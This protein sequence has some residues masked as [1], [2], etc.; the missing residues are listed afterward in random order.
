MRVAF[1]LTQSLE[2]PS[3]LGRYF[4]LAKELA[5]REY[6][7]HIIAPHHCFSSLKKHSLC[8][9]GVYIHYVSQMHVKKIGNEK[10]YFRPVPLLWIAFVSTV[11]LT[12][13]LFKIKPDIVQLGKPQPMNGLAAWIY[14]RFKRKPMYVDC[15]DYEAA[16]NR[17][18]GKWQRKAIVWFEDNLPLHADAVTVNTHFTLKRLISVGCAPNRIIYV[19]NGVD[20]ARFSVADEKEVDAL[21]AKH[22]LF[23]KRIILYV[24]SMSLISHSV[25]LLLK[26]FARASVAIDNGILVLVGGGEDYQTLLELSSQLGIANKVIYVGK[27]KPEIVPIYY[28]LADVTI[29]PV[30]D[31]DASRGRSPLKIFESFALGIPVI[32]GDVGD[33]R[34]ILRDGDYGFLTKPGSVDDLAKSLVDALSNEMRLE[35][36]KKKI[37]AERERSEIYWDLL[38]DKFINIYKAKASV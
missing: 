32:T 2:S 38:V 35:K 9:E 21:C 36:M 28:R 29:D 16:S 22:R 20:R 27:V 18:S 12:L 31:D 17:F 34:I 15:D 6:E 30:V 26:A 3:G 14:T 4:P 13:S 10:Y 33:R 5:K 23:N 25:D 37:L 19:P 7:V 11:Q 8:Y 1:V 24:G